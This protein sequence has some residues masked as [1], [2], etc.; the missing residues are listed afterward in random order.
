MKIVIL[1]ITVLILFWIFYW[2]KT[3][4]EKCGSWLNFQKES[5]S[6][7]SHMHQ[8]VVVKF[9]ECAK[10]KYFKSVESNRYSGRDLWGHY[11]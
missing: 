9:W 11:H 5:E 8:I 2:Y 10:C 7:D 4:C 1:I 6:T 3:R